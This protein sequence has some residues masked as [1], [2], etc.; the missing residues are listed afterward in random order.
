MILGSEEAILKGWAQHFEELLS[1]N[2][3]EHVENMTTVH[4]QGNFE[5]EEPVPTINEI[6]QAI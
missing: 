1:G 6:E 4:N 3:F 5:V 2:A